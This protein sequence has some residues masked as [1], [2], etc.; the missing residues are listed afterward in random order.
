MEAIWCLVGRLTGFPISYPLYPSHIPLQTRS[1]VLFLFICVCVFKYKNTTHTR[2]LAHSW[3][4]VGV[5]T[6]GE[7]TKVWGLGPFPTF[8][9]EPWFYSHIFLLQ[10]GF[11]LRR[12]LG[13]WATMEFLYGCVIFDVGV[14][15]NSGRWDL[16]KNLLIEIGFMVSGKDFFVAWKDAHE[17]VV[18]SFLLV[19]AE[20]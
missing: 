5:K 19:V 7:A 8:L 15:W 13:E 12:N 17:V 16:R 18:S 9:I 3:T 4:H 14:W 10:H 2:G 11:V 6:I 1:Q 20:T